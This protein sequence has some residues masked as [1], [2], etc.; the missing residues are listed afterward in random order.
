MK[1]KIGQA[2]ALLAIVF[3]CSMAFAAG[4]EAKED[5]V[6]DNNNDDSD[7]GDGDDDTDDD[8][9]SDTDDDSDSDS[10]SDDDDD[11]DNDGDGCQGVDFLFV[12]DSSISMGDE[13]QNLINSFPGFMEAITSA[14]GLDDFHIMAVDSDSIYVAS[15]MV[16]H[17]CT[18]P[19]G[20]A[21]WCSSALMNHYECSETGGSPYY[22]CQ[23]WLTGDPTSPNCDNL[24]GG[25]HIG[26]NT[27]TVCSI[28]GG[29]RYLI[30][31]QS[32]LHGTF[33]CI[34]NVGIEGNGHE[35]LMEAMALSVGP[36]D[37]E[38]TCNEGFIRDDAILV[39]TFI[40]DEDEA[41]TQAGEVCS[42]GTPESWK[43]ALV[44]AKDGNEDAIVV[45][46]LFGDN[47]MTDGICMPYE[48][49]SGTGAEASPLMREFLEWF[50]D[51]GHYCS[52]CLEDYTECFLEAVSTIDTTC[53]ELVI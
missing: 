25:G 13:Q 30:E 4:C 10:D 26:A 34:A 15:D 19:G 53:D 40:T 51:Q 48:P 31:G 7:D 33:A 23:E 35:R 8:S 24:L 20:C 2:M 17:A 43:E 27:G 14:L 46:G 18:N 1:T 39:V 45:L 29:N 12:V 50:G 37:E 41:C 11:D 47:D 3:I 32:D 22:N 36:F 52:V 28:E 6:S 49:S 38:G 5:M 44:E 16:R 42:E 21:T 9:D